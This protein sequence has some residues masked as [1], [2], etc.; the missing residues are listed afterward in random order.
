VLAEHG[1]M[2]EL[3]PTH[4]DF[5]SLFEEILQSLEKA[6]LQDFPIGQ[7]LRLHSL[8]AT[9]ALLPRPDGPFI[10]THMD[11]RTGKQLGQFAKNVFDELIGFFLAWAEDVRGYVLRAAELV[12]IAGAEQV[13]VGEDG[14]A[15][16]CG[17][18][19]LRH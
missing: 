11:V 3:V 10:A 14:S 8:L 1:G 6:V 15:G 16:M 9:L 7:V 2:I 13:G 18:I 12:W 5:A 19:N 17:N 4:D